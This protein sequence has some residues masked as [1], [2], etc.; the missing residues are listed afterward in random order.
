[1]N[2]FIIPSWYPS[3]INLAWGIFCK[4]QAEALATIFPDDNFSLSL[5][6]QNYVNTFLEVKDHFKNIKKVVHFMKMQKSQEALRK[7]LV[8]YNSPA[9]TWTRKIAK[10]NINGIIK[11]NENNFRLFSQYFGKPDIIHAHVGYPA[12]YIAMHLSKKF[13]IP[14]V[15]TEHMAPFPFE[16]FLNKKKLIP[17]IYQSL[18]VASKIIAVSPSLKQEIEKY[19][20]SN[21]TYIPNMVNETLFYP[22]FS[23]ENEMFTFFFLG[24]LIP[25]KGV[26]ALLE[27]I[28]LLEHLPNLR[29]R[30]GGEGILEEAYKAKTHAFG[31]ARK[32]EWLGFLNKSQAIEEFQ[33]CNAF[34]L[35]SR[36]ESLGVVLLEAIAC[37]KPIIATRCGGPE[38]IVNEKNGV[39]V[40]VDDVQGLAQAMQQMI[41]EYDKYN[42][43]IIRKDFEERFSRPVVANQIMNVYKDAI[44]EFHREN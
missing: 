35:S 34:V 26:D 16:V 3:G 27:A 19:G 11:A 13:K 12:G 44:A 38:V 43:S 23:E 18:L 40:D 36:Q 5:W 29:F 39:L 37:G 28:K 25:R 42:P 22:V 24:G 8:A 7:N 30:I 17:E 14:F 1:M 33:R 2:V 15:I 4:E 20:L 31:I 9:L 41:A 21:V 6:G 32:I 10:G